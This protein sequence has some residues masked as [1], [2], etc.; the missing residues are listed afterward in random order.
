MRGRENEPP[1]PEPLAYFI[2]WTTYG[3]WLPGDE[4][5]W[6]QYRAG[7]KLGDA[8]REFDAAVTMT[9][10][11]CRLNRVQRAAVESQIVETCSHYRWELLAAN[12]RS[13]HVHVVLVAP[14]HPR[15]VRTRL[16]AWCTRR[17]KKLESQNGFRAMR[18]HWWA[19]RG[20]ERY[21][22]DE[23]SLFA[24]IEYVRDEQD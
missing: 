15:I 5:G 23:S 16:K 1:L 19:E 24:A 13:N 4:R 7:R 17:L 20:S 21:I 14:L 3:T 9:E 2:T 18:D 11:A 22:N 12:C 6:C 8:S 10:N